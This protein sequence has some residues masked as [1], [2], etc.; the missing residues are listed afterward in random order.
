MG[1]RYYLYLDRKR[2]ALSCSCSGS[3][4]SH[5]CFGWAMSERMT[6]LLVTDALKMALFH[7]GMPQDV[8]VHSDRGVHYCSHDYQKLLKANRLICSMSKKGDCFDNA[9]MESWNHSL[10][11]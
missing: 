2:L 8:I 11:S 4:F 10:E 7:R 5:G 9:A 1:K 6:A 3:L